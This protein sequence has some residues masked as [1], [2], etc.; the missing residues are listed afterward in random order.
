MTLTQEKEIILENNTFEG[1]MLTTMGIPKKVLNLEKTLT[2]DEYQRYF[3]ELRD[4]I[5]RQ[6]GT[7]GMVNL[8]NNIKTIKK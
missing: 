8:L 5:C 2:D 3:E 4:R 1:V 7:Q 6:I